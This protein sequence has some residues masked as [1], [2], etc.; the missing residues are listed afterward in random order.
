MRTKIRTK[1]IGV[2]SSILCVSLLFSGF[3][4]YF[5]VTQIIREQSI[6]DSLVKLS[7]NGLQLKRIQEQTQQIAEYIIVDTEIQ[8]LIYQEKP[9]SIEDDYF[10]KLTVGEKLKNLL[11]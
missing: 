8:N 10:H 4:T 6:Q 5:Y 9:L 7:Q 1:I 11:C 2:T 3:F